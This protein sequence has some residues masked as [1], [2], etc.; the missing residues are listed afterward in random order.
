MPA[1][2][3]RAMRWS[4]GESALAA[5]PA[6]TI[7]YAEEGEARE[8]HDCLADGQM[9]MELPAGTTRLTYK[10]QPFVVTISASATRHPEA[11]WH[12]NSLE[13]LSVPGL[14]FR[15]TPRLRIEQGTGFS[16]YA[17]AHELFVRT[18]GK[19]LPLLAQ[20]RAPGCAG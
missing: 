19:E 11:Y 10:Q 13:A 14:L 9:L 6:R 3:P 20:A 15:G 7:V 18:Q 5:M 16:S 17:P 2:S 12:G 4:K 1:C 8:L